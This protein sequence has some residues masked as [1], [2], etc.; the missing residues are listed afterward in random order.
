MSIVF[1]GFSRF[2]SPPG[3]TVPLFRAS[4]STVTTAACGISPADRTGPPAASPQ[5]WPMRGVGGGNRSAEALH[6]TRWPRCGVLF[7]DPLAPPHLVGLPD[8][9]GGAY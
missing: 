5:Q 7:E 3:R 2:P 8:N 6:V 4:P 1:A 9:R